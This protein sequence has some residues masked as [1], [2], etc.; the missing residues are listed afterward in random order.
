MID[1]VAGHQ[2]GR[3]RQGADHFGLQ[4]GCA[5]AVVHHHQGVWI[6]LHEDIG[7]ELSQRPAFPDCGVGGTFSEVTPGLVGNEH[8]SAAVGQ[9][10][11]QSL[12]EVGFNPAA[13]MRILHAGG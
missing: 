7:G 2:H 4:F 13:K 5:A 10:L 8:G 9:A 12:V 6:L 3:M 11:G 1:A